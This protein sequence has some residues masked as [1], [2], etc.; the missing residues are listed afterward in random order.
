MATIRDV[1]TRAGFSTTT[2]SFV[3]NDA[4]LASSIAKATQERIRKAARELG[5]EPN[6]FARSLRAKNSNVV[7]VVVFDITDPYCSQVLRG[8]ETI[9]Y[10]SRFFLPLLA[11]IQNN[12]THLK[13]YMKTFLDRH[14]EGLIV[15]ASSLSMEEELLS[16]LEDCHIPIV[17]IGRESSDRKFRSVTIDN[18]EGARLAL[19]HLYSLG[20]RDIAFI[21]GPRAFIESSQRWG[22]IESCSDELGLKLNSKLIVELRNPTSSSEGAVESTL[23][24]LSRRRKFTAL[25]AYDDLTAFGAIRTLEQAGIGVPGACSIVGFDDISM[26][27]YYNPPLTT[28]RQDMSLLGATGSQM[29]LDAIATP[30]LPFES[31]RLQPQLVVRRSTASR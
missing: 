15:L 17:M 7:G 29:L 11:D 3:L 26:A 14:V 9:L 8:I 1:A 27:Q 18:D 28:I 21:R 19:Q 12:R 24:L 22:A 5:Y 6:V 25:L 23:L 30:S 20:H 4:P 13:R 10:R 2:V 31:R 16:M